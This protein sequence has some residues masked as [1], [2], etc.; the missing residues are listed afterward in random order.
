MTLVDQL[1]VRRSYIH[2]VGWGNRAR[3]AR[4]TVVR[5]VSNGLIGIAQSFERGRVELAWR[6]CSLVD[7][8]EGH[9]A[10][11]QIG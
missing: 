6:R 10:E 8:R 3:I 5:S 2:F 1:L 7:G 4:S 9:P 11:V